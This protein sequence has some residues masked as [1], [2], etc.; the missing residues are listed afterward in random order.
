MGTY[1]FLGVMLDQELRWKEHCQYTMRKGVKQV[2]Q[3][4]RLTR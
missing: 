3:Y 1:K 4:W 2:T